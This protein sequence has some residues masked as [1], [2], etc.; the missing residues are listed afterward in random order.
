LTKV[1]LTPL[2][3][4]PSISKRCGRYHRARSGYFFLFVHLFNHDQSD[5]KSTNV[6]KG[7]ALSSKFALFLF[8]LR[9]RFWNWASTFR[10]KNKIEKLMQFKIWVKMHSLK[11]FLTITK[12][13]WKSFSIHSMV[14]ERTLWFRK[15]LY[16]KLW[17]HFTN[18]IWKFPNFM[19]TFWKWRVVD[20]LRKNSISG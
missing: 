9:V 12:K 4:L 5:L 14:I 17:K 2:W 11:N 7:K 18:E 6:A 19:S 20:F 10:I 3:N 16:L 15:S 8:C 1:S 13:Y